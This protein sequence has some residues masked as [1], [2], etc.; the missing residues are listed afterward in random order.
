MRAWLAV[1]V[2]LGAIACGGGKDSGTC[3]GMGE[4]TVYLNDAATGNPVMGSIEW[5]DAN[6]DTG[7]MDCPGQC[8]FS[9]PP[10]TLIVTGTVDGATQDQNIVVST[11]EDCANPPFNG[12][13]LEF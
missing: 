12:V 11:S 10:G 7:S 9:A 5:V 3:E 13:E 6:A 2:A 1:G 4:V 8:V